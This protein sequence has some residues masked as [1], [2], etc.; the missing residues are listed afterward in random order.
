MPPVK[1]KTAKK[2][3]GLLGAKEP[4]AF[5]LVNKRGKSPV[6]I[7]CDHASNRIPK[8]LGTLGLSAAERKMHIAWDPGTA[9]IGRYLAKKLNAP[10]LLAN[11]S[12][13]V[14]DLNRGPDNAECMR[15]VSDHVKIPGNRRLT[16]TAQNQRLDALYQ[17]YHDEI[18]RLMDSV[19]ERGEVPLLLSIHS[20]TPQMEGFD[21]PWQIGVMWNREKTLSK[22]LI[23]NLKRDNKGW[24]I[25]DNQP[26]SLKNHN[27]GKSTIARH[28]EDR[29]LPCL[30]VE[31]RQDLVG[32]SR[33]QAERMAAR[34]LK[35][36]LPILND[37][38]TYRGR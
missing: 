25:G 7:V 15:D 9:H 38:K 33:A 11:Y 10:V 32:K 17:P 8:K 35:S 12:R 34:F 16:R 21:R 2:T 30:I 36:L 13:L 19:L 31:F 18:A 37:P 23:A 22:K 24:M 29:K 28:G 4:A 27:G 20:F 5:T 1:K 26:Y 3:T 6:V 14:V